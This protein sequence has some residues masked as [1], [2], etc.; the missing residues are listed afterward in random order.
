MVSLRACLVLLLGAL[1]AGASRDFYK[2]LGIPRSADE[3]VIKKACASSSF[4][5]PRAAL[6]L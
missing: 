2:I 6:A 4:C 3:G 5:L 1:A